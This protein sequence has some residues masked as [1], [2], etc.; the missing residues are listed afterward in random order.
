MAV[1]DLS[2]AGTH[3]VG[4][5]ARAANDHIGVDLKSRKGPGKQGKC[6]PMPATHHREAVQRKGVNIGVGELGKRSSGVIERRMEGCVWGTRASKRGRP[7]Q[8]HR[9]GLGNRER[10][11]S[12]ATPPPARAPGLQILM[13]SDSNRAVTT[14][15]LGDLHNLTRVHR[16]RADTRGGSGTRKPRVVFLD[17]VARLSGGEIALLRLL[18]ALLDEVDV[19]VILGEDGP[20]VARLEGLGIPV[21]VMPLAPR[22]RDLRKD[23][24]GS[25]PHRSG[26]NRSYRDL[27][28][29][30]ASAPS[31]FGG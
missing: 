21:E 9:A 11:R 2:T 15:L 18:P 3:T 19:H 25:Q 17:H 8:P 31:C 7:A 12:C 26:R 22:V 24:I 13:E 14:F 5:T 10:S 6:H 4:P 16:G 28:P 1:H 23:R 20:L 29:A 30:A 27:R